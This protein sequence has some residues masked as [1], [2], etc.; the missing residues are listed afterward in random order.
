ME[1]MIPVYQER[2]EKNLALSKL[3][4]L[5]GATVALV[6]DN[7][8]AEFTDEL[9]AELARTYGALVKKLVKPWGSAPSPESLIAQAAEC[10]VAVVGIAL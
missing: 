3:E 2:E 7:Y 8:D 9:E 5:K 6:D 10:D 1:I 4:S